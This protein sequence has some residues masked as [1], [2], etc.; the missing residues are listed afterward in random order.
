MELKKVVDTVAWRI[1][2]GFIVGMSLAGLVGVEAMGIANGLIAVSMVLLAL[3]SVGMP[4]I[5]L[6]TMT[7]EWDT[8][9]IMMTFLIEPRRWRVVV[10]K[11]A[12]ALLVAAVVLIVVAVATLAISFAISAVRGDS[13]L[14]SEIVESFRYGWLY[15]IV[16]ETCALGLALTLLGIAWGSLL[17][18]T[19]ISMVAV[20]GVALMP[21]MAITEVFDETMAL[22]FGQMAPVLWLTGEEPFGPWVITSVNLWCLAPLVGGFWRQSRREVR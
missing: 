1:L 14:M 10:A 19:P 12:A 16:S 2:L 15:Q 22:W 21:A 5:G 6:F 17:L 9:S 18:S 8:R 7:S 20:A 11:A 3:V 4:M 13:R